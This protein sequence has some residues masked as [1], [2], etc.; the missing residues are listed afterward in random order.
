VLLWLLVVLRGLAR[1]S[2]VVTK[3]YLEFSVTFKNKC[4]TRSLPKL[5]YF[6]S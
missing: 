2:D 1:A 3:I 5:L 6:L 4:E